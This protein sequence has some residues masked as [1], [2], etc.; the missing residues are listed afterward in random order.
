MDE[1]VPG[2]APGIEPGCGIEET[3]G[4]SPPAGP[5]TMCASGPAC[6]SPAFSA[7]EPSPE[8]TSATRAPVRRGETV[9]TSLAGYPRA[10][11]FHAGLLTARLGFN[12]AH[13]WGPRRDRHLSAVPRDL[14]LLRGTALFLGLQERRQEQ[15]REKIAE[16]V[17]PLIEDAGTERHAGVW[18][19][20]MDQLEDPFFGDPSEQCR[21]FLGPVRRVVGRLKDLHL[22]ALDSADCSAY[23]LGYSVG[24]G[25]YFDL[26]SP[27]PPDNRPVVVRPGD[28]PRPERR[29]RFL[30]RRPG[31]LPPPEG[32]LEEVR[33]RG[34]KAGVAEQ[35]LKARTSSR[36]GA[37]RKAGWRRS[38]P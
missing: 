21:E 10:A 37:T 13:F 5:A 29:F 9:L 32:W 28:P 20:L 17:S 14:E 33:I 3:S 19:E 15:I 34:L 12:L 35:L 27:E 30:A 7:S 6:D 16:A 23:L 18:L 36:D 24:L 2:G 31:E 11:A 1:P 22:N 8:G 26:L 38:G 4:A 25:A